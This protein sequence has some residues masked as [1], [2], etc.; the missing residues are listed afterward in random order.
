M[1]RVLFVSKGSEHPAGRYRVTQYLG[2]LV[3]HGVQPQVVP[4]PDSVL[5]WR[6]LF[7]AANP[8]DIIVI[9][10][11][12]LPIL[13]MLMVRR[14][15]ARLIYDVDDAV[16]YASS[17]HDSQDSATRMRQFVSMASKCDAVT[18]GNSYLKSLAEPHNKRVWIIP[19]AVDTRK[20]RLNDHSRQPDKVTL[21]WIGGRK[22]LVFLKE[23]GPVMDRLAEKHP[24][25]QLK[26]I[27][28]EFFDCAKMPVVK[29]QWDEKT[30]ADEVRTFDIGI[31]PLPDD[32]WSRGKCATKLLQCMA[33]GVP[34]VASPVGVHTD[35]IKEG[36]NGMLATNHDEWFAKLSALTGDIET[37]RRLGLAGRKTVEESYSLEATAPKMLEVFKAVLAQGS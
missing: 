35:I 11:K 7:L 31:A 16:M 26:M 18:V 9:Q 27:C 10:K 30:E 24:N 19:T 12:R 8:H 20:Y 28:N 22:S 4:F 23:L 37:R 29:T 14:G 2:W 1:I 13:P 25:V 21:G 17:R 6:G 32:V 5:D 34:S 33:A 3:E 36:V 15:H